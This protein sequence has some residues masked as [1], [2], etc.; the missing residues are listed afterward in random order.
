MKAMGLAE[1]AMLVTLSV[2][3]GGSFFFIG[4]LVKV[5]PPLTIVA[6]RLLIAAAVLLL[7]LKLTGRRVP[8]SGPVILAC[9]GMGLLNN[10]LPFSLIVWGQ[11]RIESGLASVFN[12]T[13]PL[14]GVVVAHFLTRD[15]KMS[16]NR[17]AGV[18]SGFAGVAI[19]IGASAFSGLTNS[20]EG[21][22]AVLGAAL[23]YA[24]AGVFGRRFRRL[25]VDPVTAAAGQITAAA[26][27]MLP[28][29]MVIERPFALIAGAPPFAWAALA[30]MA[31]FS[32]AFAYVLYFR[33]LSSAGATNI[34]LVT[35]LVPVSAIL[36]GVFVLGEHLAPRHFFGMGLIAIGLAAIDGRLFRCR[37]GRSKRAG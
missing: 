6:L 11:T 26:I 14:F 4:V 30:A 7:V 34:M 16:V 5:L 25:G 20:L 28:L 23:S 27:I 32:T 36:L 31:V 2:L 12:A 33:I 24:F 8:V 18:V 10:A 37:I 17:L 13:T 15:E 19:M 22:V 29:A 35:F 3:W 21:E 1:W 9:L